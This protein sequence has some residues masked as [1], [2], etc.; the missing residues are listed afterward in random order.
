MRRLNE[1]STDVEGFQLELVLVIQIEMYDHVV[2]SVHLS[3]T[4]AQGLVHWTA[5][6][7][8]NDRILMLL[9]ENVM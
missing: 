7:F 1:H 6:L 3:V 2:H 9:M 5:T 8:L 4:A